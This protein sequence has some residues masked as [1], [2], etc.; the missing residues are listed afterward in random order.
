[1]SIC[2]REHET[3]TETVL[4]CELNEESRLCVVRTAEHAR[5][6]NGIFLD[7][8]T[9]IHAHTHTLPYMISKRNLPFYRLFSQFSFSLSL[10]PRCHSERFCRMAE[11]SSRR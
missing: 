11:E 3:G 5:L 2:K 7:K 4:H 8:Q 1:M 10:S 6:G 9:N